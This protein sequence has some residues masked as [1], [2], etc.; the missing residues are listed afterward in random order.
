MATA[1]VTAEDVNVVIV[2]WRG[3]SLPLY[4]QATDQTD[5]RTLLWALIES[6][7]SGRV[8]D[9]DPGPL[10]V[11]ESGLLNKVESN[12]IRSEYPDSN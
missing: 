12:R 5:I 1:L 8:A 10:I 4:T 3:G 11:S 9:P 2:D 7:D 6:I